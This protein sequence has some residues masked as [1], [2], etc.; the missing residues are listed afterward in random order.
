MRWP[1]GE[2]GW[3]GLIPPFD[4]AA[5]PA[6]TSASAATANTT[7]R[8]LD[9]TAGHSMNVAESRVELPSGVPEGFQVYVNGVLQQPGKDYRRA[10][11]ELVFDRSMAG[12]GRLGFWR[13]LSLFFGIA[14]TYRQT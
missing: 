8:V 14:G 2:R 6:P 12:E 9:R 5:A 7:A 11:N 3:T 13:W 1:F 10:G 4:A